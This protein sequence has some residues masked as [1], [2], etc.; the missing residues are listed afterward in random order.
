[1]Y[2]H[3]MYIHYRRVRKTKSSRSEGPKAGLKLEVRLLVS[4]YNMA[5]YSQQGIYFNTHLQ[6][7]LR[8]SVS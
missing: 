7:L 2:I 4:Q 8:S 3:Y 5:M 1:M 6:V